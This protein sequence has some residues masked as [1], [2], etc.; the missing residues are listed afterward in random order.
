MKNALAWIGRILLVL[1]GVLLLA[2]AYVWSQLPK[3]GPERIDAGDGI[4]GVLT[5][6]SYAWIVKTANGA[7]LIDAGVDPDGGAILAELQHQGL[8]PD[9][10][11]AVLI[12]H[13]HADHWAGARLFPNAKLL[14]GEGDLPMLRGEVR[15]TAPMAKLFAN[16][17]NTGAPPA[18]VE[19]VKDGQLLEFDGASFRAYHVPG[20]T[21]GSTMFLYG[22]TLFTGDSLLGSGDQFRVLG[23]IISEDE[24]RNLESLKRLQGEPFTRIADGHTGVHDE[25]QPKLGA[26]L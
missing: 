3:P 8:K 9:Q 17:A 21:P 25:A 14:I 24:E 1:V 19:G 26:L 5:Q 18:N 6:G 23:G 10:V 12:T 4:T 13:A 16:V 20:H 7:V 22:D 11:K 2:V 15:P